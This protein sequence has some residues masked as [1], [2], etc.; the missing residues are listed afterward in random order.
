M[1]YLIIVVLALA[2]VGGFAF[3]KYAPNF[4]ETKPAAPTNANLTIWGFEPDE[5]TIKLAIAEYQKTH[6]D[7]TIN[8]VKQSRLNYRSRVQTQIGSN[9]GPDIL[10]MHNSW[11]PMLMKTNAL[12]ASPASAF[13]L[14]DY[15]SEF[16]PIAKDT[17]VYNNQIYGVSTGVDGLL[18]YYNEDIIKA[19]GVVVPQDWAQFT[20]VAVR[21]TVPN[22]DGTIR[23]AGAAMGT[24][25]NVDY[26]S[27]IVGLLFLQEPGA[28][29]EQP[30][31]P[32]GANVIKFY[33]DFVTDPTKKVWDQ[34]L[35]NSTQMFA[36]GNL[37]FYFGPSSRAAEI[38]ALNPNLNFKV[39]KVPQLPG[40]DIYWGSYW[41][42]GVSGSS[43]YKDQAW[44]FLQFL[45]SA[46]TEQMIYAQQ[47]QQ[48][49]IGE[50][51]SR[52]DLKK[53]LEGDPV[54]GLVVTQA[55]NFKNWYLNSYT[56]DQGI[57]DAMID[58]YKQA[59]DGVVAGQNPLSMLQSTATSIQKILSDYLP[60][61]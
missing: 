30:N 26:W 14:G 33:T 52:V 36:D 54:L 31:T 32:S 29:L 2:V 40:K 19:A 8:F 43:Q 58:A 38:R 21:T 17:L 24:T 15:I 51:Y 4:A 41:G 45:S 49:G 7:V 47:V 5:K 39:T 53:Q 56:E 61:K 55:P 9:Q 22:P 3:W 1:K 37:T 46:P 13:S 11:V 50:A 60:A 48:K 42:W 25:T 59:V 44:E 20:A 27:E 12:S 16:Y 28:S 34:N 57:N 23:T 18:L 6:P 35:A 10:V